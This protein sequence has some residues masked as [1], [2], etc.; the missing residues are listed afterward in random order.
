MTG[1]AHA[2]TAHSAPDRGSAAANKALEYA[3]DLVLD[4][5]AKLLLLHVQQA[6]HGRNASSGLK[7]FERIE[8]LRITE[9]EM[10]RQEA[11]RIIRA[12]EGAARAKGVEEI[13]TI[14]AEGDAAAEIILA[15]KVRHVDTIVIGSRGLGTLEGLLLGSVSHKVAQ[16]APCTCIIVR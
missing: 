6:H 15:A 16:M 4:T 3:I 9:A 14:I 10:L 2:S 1:K 5:K 13:E 7:E 8:Q 12:C 11:E